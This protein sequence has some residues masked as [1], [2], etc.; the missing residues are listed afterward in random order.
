MYTSVDIPYGLRGCADRW[1]LGLFASDMSL[2]SPL[3]PSSLG[4]S[5][6]PRPEGEIPS[7]SS[8]GSLDGGGAEL[9]RRRGQND[10]YPRI[11]DARVARNPFLCCHRS[12]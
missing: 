12:A 8:L 10:P 7:D 11:L 9:A 5:P 6:P 3:W 4:P 1:M 2:K